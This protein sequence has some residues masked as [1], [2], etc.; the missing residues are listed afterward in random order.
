MNIEL[1]VAASENNL[2]AMKKLYQAGDRLFI[3]L[4][5]AAQGGHKEALEFLLTLE[6]T[7]EDQQEGMREGLFYASQNGHLEIVELLLA[8]KASLKRKG[9]SALHAAAGQGHCDIVLK[10]IAA[11]IKVNVTDSDKCTP[12]FEAVANKHPE[13]I[14]SLLEK[15]ADPIHKN[16]FGL[17]PSEL[18]REYG[19]D[20]IKAL[21]LN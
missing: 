19:T 15:G 16:R 4:A 8:D 14:K 2:E 10:L 20:E 7:S 3:A 1:N 18:A 5:M 11:G 21:I 17:T 12:L 6:T 13:V 9:R